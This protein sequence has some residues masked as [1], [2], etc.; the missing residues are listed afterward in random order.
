MQTIARF[1]LTYKQTQH[2]STKNSSWQVELTRM[3]S[4][5]H[6]QHVIFDMPATK[7]TE[8]TEFEFY[9]NDNDFIDY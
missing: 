6:A 8:L 4:D 3:T 1:S 7:S 2:I 5:R 9:V